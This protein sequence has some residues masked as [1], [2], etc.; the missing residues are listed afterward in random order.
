[1]LPFQWQVKH[2]ELSSG[3]KGQWFESTRAYEASLL[4]VTLFLLVPNHSEVVDNC[5][6]AQLPLNELMSPV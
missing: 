4:E 5:A 3:T 2:G 6:L 1:M